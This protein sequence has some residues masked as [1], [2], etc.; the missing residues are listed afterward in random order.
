MPQ[1]CFSLTHILIVGGTSPI[2]CGTIGQKG[3]SWASTTRF[4][5][6]GLLFHDGNNYR[7]PKTTVII[8]NCHPYFA[9]EFGREQLNTNR[10]RLV[11]INAR[12]AGHFR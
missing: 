12:A 9:T 1:T 5:I 11:Q 2:Y 6:G 10:E 4:F 3:Q 8:I 7:K